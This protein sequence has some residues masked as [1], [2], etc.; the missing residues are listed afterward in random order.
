MSQKIVKDSI[1]V[2]V[3]M[4]QLTPIDNEETKPI[5]MILRVFSLLSYFELSSTCDKVES[6]FVSYMHSETINSLLKLMFKLFLFLHLLSMALNFMVTIEN[7]FNVYDTWL[8]NEN[9]SYSSPIEKYVIGWY[10]GST[11]LSTVGF[12]EIIPAN[13]IE[14]FVISIIEVCCCMTFGYFVNA[15]GEIIKMRSEASEK[16]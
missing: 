7:A 10:W 14:R 4:L 9:L 13:N 5:F 12:G 3:I 11:I 15:I 1:S 8:N 6:L 2:L 16:Y